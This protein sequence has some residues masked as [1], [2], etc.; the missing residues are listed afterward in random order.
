MKHIRELVPMMVCHES[1]VSPLVDSSFR[2]PRKRQFLSALD[3]YQAGKPRSFQQPSCH[4]CGKINNDIKAEGKTFLKRDGCKN[5]IAAAW[6]C[7]KVRV[8]VSYQSTLCIVD[9]L[10]VPVGL[11]ESLVE[12]P[13]G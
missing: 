12:T 4:S 11:P 1:T 9:I 7:D 13:Q 5:K 3:H 2:G 8:A 6:H 10:A